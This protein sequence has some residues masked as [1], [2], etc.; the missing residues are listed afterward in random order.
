MCPNLGKA[1]Q[2]GLV[3]GF[4]II[5][6]LGEVV[7]GYILCN[8]VVLQHVRRRNSVIANLMEKPICEQGNCAPFAGGGVP[9]VDVIRF[10]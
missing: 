4:D 2:P 5:T 6:T 1:N 8:L 3:F 10:W 7:R 9:K